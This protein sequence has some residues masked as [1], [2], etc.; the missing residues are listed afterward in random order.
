LKEAK[1]SKASVLHP[2]PRVDELDVALDSDVRAVYFEQA[3]YGVPV[4]MALISLLL[5]IGQNEL[6]RYEGGFAAERLPTYDQPLGLGIRC[7]NQNC[8]VHDETEAPYVRNKFHVVKHVGQPKLRCLYCET[9]IESFSIAN[10]KNK[11]YMND[12][13]ALLKIANH[14]LKDFVFFE[15]E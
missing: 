1:Y 13:D 4:R 11:W 9:D 5:G 12:R 7:R 8:I 10:K 14:N 3:A 2:L 15:S 6:R